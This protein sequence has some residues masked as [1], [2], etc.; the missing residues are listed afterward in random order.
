M[1]DVCGRT[2][3]VVVALCIADRPAAAS[4]GYQLTGNV[5]H[6]ETRPTSSVTAASVAPI[7]WFARSEALRQRGLDIPE[8]LPCDRPGDKP[9]VYYRTDLDTDAVRDVNRIEVTFYL[10]FSQDIGPGCHSNDLE[11]ITITLLVD[12]RGRPDCTGRIRSVTAD[13]HGSRYYAGVPRAVHLAHPASAEPLA[14]DVAANSL[15]WCCCESRPGVRID[16]QGIVEW[17]V[18]TIA[19]LRLVAQQRLHFASQCIVITAGLTQ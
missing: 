1:P 4:S 3:F 19:R 7:L 18:Q 12:C 9:V 17:D 8:P 13:A 14:D 11:T 6:Y 10:Y 15:A 16:S 5:I 2:L